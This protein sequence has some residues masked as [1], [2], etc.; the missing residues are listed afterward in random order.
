MEHF[1][2]LLS[3]CP[4]STASR[5]C[6]GTMP[7]ERSKSF[8]KD[9]DAVDFVVDLSEADFWQLLFGEIGWETESTPMFSGTSRDLSVF[10][11]VV[12]QTRCHLLVSRPV[13]RRRMRK[14]MN[15]SFERPYRPVDL[16]TPLTQAFP[17]MAMAEKPHGRSH[18]R[19]VRSSLADLSPR[20]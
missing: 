10:S 9:T 6:Y 16:N 17:F 8:L 12:S 2:R 7:M 3:N 4:P 11:H 5:L 18:I 1:H 20:R 14:A 13:L 19:H 15:T